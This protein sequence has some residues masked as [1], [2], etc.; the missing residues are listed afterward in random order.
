M[1]NVKKISYV[2]S[3]LWIVFS[4]S[5]CSTISEQ[6]PPDAVVVIDDDEMEMMKGGYQWE[7]KG[8]F[9]NSAVIADAESPY[10]IAKNIDSVEIQSNSKGNVEFNDE[11]EPQIQAYLWE[12]DIQGD[13]LLVNDREITMPTET[14][15]HVIEV[16]AQW[17]NGNASYTFVV[18]V[19]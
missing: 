4:I 9:S 17:S 16:S 8:L 5:G 10:Q 15:R 2:L 7:T 6:E 3:L 14:G 18:E 1:N 12:G 11:S 13:E 19:K